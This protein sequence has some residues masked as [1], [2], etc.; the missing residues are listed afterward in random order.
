MA[1]SS[2]PVGLLTRTFPLLASLMSRLLESF[3][4]DSASRSSVIMKASASRP[5]IPFPL[6]FVLSISWRYLYSAFTLPT[7]FHALS[8]HRSPL[9]PT[10]ARRTCSLSLD[11]TQHDSS[12]FPSSLNRNL[13]KCPKTKF[14]LS[15]LHEWYHIY[16]RCLSIFLGVSPAFVPISVTF[17]VVPPRSK[18]F[19]HRAC[20]PPSG[21][22]R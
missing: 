10:H 19:L 22:L 16:S 14:R 6:G 4:T 13:S 18:F 9:R 12:K 7:P 17:H 8:S 11:P 20:I 5:I 21:I 3:I 1:L 15:L 2:H